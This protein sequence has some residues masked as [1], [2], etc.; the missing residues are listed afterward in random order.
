MGEL[1]MQL[2]A[3]KTTVCLSLPTG[4]GCPNPPRAAFLQVVKR[5]E[6]ISNV[7]SLFSFRVGT[8]VPIH[9]HHMADKGRPRRTRHSQRPNRQNSPPGRF[10]RDTRTGSKSNRRTS[11]FRV[12]TIS[13][14]CPREPVLPL[15]SGPEPDA[16]PQSPAGFGPTDGH[17]RLRPGTLH[18]QQEP[19]TTRFAATSEMARPGLEPGTPRFSVVCSTS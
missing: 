12:V 1:Y 13:P 16:Q 6:P 5:A 7:V 11:R 9:P 18:I 4:C 17:R 14:T 8:G 19:E 2:D 10:A 15:D 3:R